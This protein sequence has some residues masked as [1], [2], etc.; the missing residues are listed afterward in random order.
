[1]TNSLNASWGD[2]GTGHFWAVGVGGT[3]LH[4]DTA[5]FLDESVTAVSSLLGVCGVTGGA[6]PDVWAVGTGGYVAHNDGSGWTAELPRPTTETIFSV[7][8][9]SNDVFA[10]TESGAILHKAR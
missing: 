9:T 10:V 5:T 8:C 3:I 4:W 7:Y 1:M 2:P 6:N